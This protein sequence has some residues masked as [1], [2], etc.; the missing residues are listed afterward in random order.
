VDG[1]TWP[2]SYS[3]VKRSAS[4]SETGALELR[5]L[6]EIGEAVAEA[7]EAAL[8]A[9]VVHRDINPENIFLT[10]GGQRKILD[11]GLAKIQADAVPSSSTMPTVDVVPA[12][13]TEPGALLGTVACMSPEQARGDDIVLRTDQFSVGVV[14]Y[15]MATGRLPFN[16]PTPA[17]IFDAIL[18]RPPQALDR[19]HPEL[20]PIIAKVLEKD[21][22]LR[23]QSARHLHSDLVRLKRD[24]E[25]GQPAA[26]RTASPTRT[27]KGI[28]SLA[29]LP[30]VTTG[31]D[32]DFEYLSEGIAE[33]L[34]NSFCELPRLRV[35]PPHS[36]FRYRG[37]DA[38]LKQAARELDVQAILT[39]RLLRRGDTLVVKISL[40]DVGRDAQ[41]WGK[42]VT[43]QMSDIFVLQDE[44]AEQVLQTLE[45][46]LTGERTRRRTIQTD[47][48]EVDHMYRKGRH[49]LAKRTPPN[50][51][52]ALD[53]YQQAIDRDPTYAAAWAGIAD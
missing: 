16:G 23:Y 38:D 35:A 52:K 14:L 26:T 44:I 42:Q 39:G 11:F 30:L 49:C 20:A 4:D 18:N 48:T 24:S 2:W 45:V 27:G 37:A 19:T 46:K 15:E 17:L 3:R 21:P 8:G 41:L 22:E 31:G 47:S 51:Q 6:L 36:S 13:R 34:I 29:V 1:T 53:F 40:A 33:S 7:L 32:A 9:G 5:A 12:H 28:D 43:R 10:T 25:S 50:T